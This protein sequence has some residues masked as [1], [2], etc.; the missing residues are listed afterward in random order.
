MVYWGSSRFL[1]CPINPCIGGLPKIAVSWAIR[2]NKRTHYSLKPVRLKAGRPL[3]TP[4]IASIT[5]YEQSQESSLWGGN[6]KC[7]QFFSP[8]STTSLN[9]RVAAYI[10]VMAIW[11]CYSTSCYICTLYC[12][13]VFSVLRR[14]LGI[15]VRPERKLKQNTIKTL[16]GSW[17]NNLLMSWSNILTL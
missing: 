2:L 9:S 4:F 5:F 8:A 1:L 13:V 12:R 14:S 7:F 17:K 16:V 3:K 10:R 6:T 11:H 15:L